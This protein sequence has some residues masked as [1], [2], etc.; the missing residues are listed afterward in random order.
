[1]IANSQRRA[2]LRLLTLELAIITTHPTALPPLLEQSELKSKR[3]FLKEVS[4]SC[5]LSVAVKGN[6]HCILYVW[7]SGEG[8]MRHFLRLVMTAAILFFMAHEIQAVVQVVIDAQQ[9]SMYGD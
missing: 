2:R 4:Q 7:R 9:Q 5:V 3:F 8:I 6:H 1:M